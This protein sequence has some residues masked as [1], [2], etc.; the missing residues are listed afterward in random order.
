[1]KHPLHRRSVVAIVFAPALSLLLG[2][3][4]STDTKATAS[5]PLEAEGPAQIIVPRTHTAIIEANSAGD[6]DFAGLYPTFELKA[7]LMNSDVRNALIERQGEYFQWDTSQKATEREKATQ[8]LSAET[9]VFLSFSTPERKND[10][11]ADNKSIWRLFLDAG[12][13]RYVGKAKKDRRLIAELQ[14]LFPFHTRWNSAYLVTFPIATNAIE[15]DS[16]RL[17]VTGPLGSRVLEFRPTGSR[18]VILAPADNTATE[19]K[20]P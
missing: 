20:S 6:S 12:G 17:T 13:R 19:P 4:A 5:S 16:V 18:G 1:M 9:S 10:N 8:E 11:L 7:T 15:T 2:A 14:S 3:C